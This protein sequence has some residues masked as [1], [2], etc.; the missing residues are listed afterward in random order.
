MNSLITMII[1]L[2]ASFTYPF[3]FKVH[4]IIALKLETHSKGQT[5]IHSYKVLYIAVV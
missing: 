3:T 5:I 1:E 2:T 4:I